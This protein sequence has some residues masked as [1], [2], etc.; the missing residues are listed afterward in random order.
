MIEGK[1]FT[2]YH[3][4]QADRPFFFPVL[5]DGQ[6]AL[7]RG[8]PMDPGPDDQDD[9]LH[10]R[11]LWYTHGSVNGFDFWSEGKGP[12]IVQ[13]R[14][15]VEE[16]G[17]GF[18]TI[19]R[20]EDPDGNVVCRDRRSHRFGVLAGAVVLDFEITI[21]ADDSELILGIPRKVRWPSG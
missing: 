18:T 16:A 9:H 2:R 14:I 8:W 10:H 21:K 12:R 5:L 17:N 3:H 4:D 1:L 7:T 19:N 13:E 20:W 15:E 6:L 11:G